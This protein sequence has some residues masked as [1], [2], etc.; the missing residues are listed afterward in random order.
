MLFLLKKRLVLKIVAKLKVCLYT[1]REVGQGAFI[2]MKNIMHYKGYVGSIEYSEDDDILF[3]KVLA[4]RSLIMYEGQS[5]KEIK[6]D[7]HRAIDAHLAY[8]EAEGIQP[9]KG[10]KGTFNVRIS[11]ELHQE[12]A[13]LAQEKE[14]SLNNIVEM[15]LS[16][17]V[18]TAQ[19]MA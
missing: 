15:A 7:F 5:L 12:A 16:K 9:E 1:E 2:I 13:I 6:E 3:G 14:T 18:K 8:C 11:P 10:F 17:Y 19:N 4:I